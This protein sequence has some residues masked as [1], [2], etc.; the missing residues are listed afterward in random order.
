MICLCSNTLILWT[1]S[2]DI[3]YDLFKLFAV[4]HKCSQWLLS[5]F[6]GLDMCI[7]RPRLTPKCIDHQWNGRI[8][9]NA[10]RRSCK[11]ANS[12]LTA[13]IGSS[14]QNRSHHTHTIDSTGLIKV[15]IMC[16]RYNNHDHKICTQSNRTGNSKFAPFYR[17]EKRDR[18]VGFIFFFI[19][20]SASKAYNNVYLSLSNAHLSH[21]HKMCVCV[22]DRKI[23]RLSATQNPET[24]GA[25]SVCCVR[26]AFRI[27]DN[28]KYCVWTAEKCAL[29]SA[30]NKIHDCNKRRRHNCTCVW[31]LHQRTHNTD[32]IRTYYHRA[33]ETSTV[34][35][36]FRG[37]FHP[38]ICTT[39]SPIIA[40]RAYLKATTNHNNHDNRA[41][42]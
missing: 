8:Q 6:L 5:T 33:R 38:P 25:S 15:R 23:T 36:I 7:L 27:P 14:P 3:L 11:H 37:F 31:S 21:I 24:M 18:E 20:V 9:L 16:I 40:M 30:H 17:R 4:P 42:N 19:I 34:I 29:C 41:R 10:V 12:N 2:F 35:S 22:S 32:K 39:S 1:F 13:I 28:N 26:A